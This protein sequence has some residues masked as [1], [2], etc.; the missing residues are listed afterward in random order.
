MYTNFHNHVK[1]IFLFVKT[2]LWASAQ[3][4]AKLI[5]KR[6]SK[7]ALSNIGAHSVVDHRLLPKTPLRGSF[8]ALGEVSLQH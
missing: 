3:R 8:S 2:M 7:P 1:I 4:S 6:F 5:L